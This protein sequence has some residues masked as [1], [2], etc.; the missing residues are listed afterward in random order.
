MLSGPPLP[1]ERSMSDET[2]FHLA[3]EQ[4]AAERAGFLDGA[5][6]G[7][8]ALR[9]RVEVLLHAHEN[10]AGFLQSPAI[11]SGATLED[12]SAGRPAP[13]RPPGTP[14]PGEIIGPYKLLQEIGE[15]GMGIVWMAEQMQPVQRKVALKIIKPGLDSRMIIARFE[16]ERQALALMDHVNIARVLDA[17]ATAAGKPYFVMELVHGVPITQYCDDHRLNPRQRLELFVPVCQA[18]QH[19]HQKGIIHRDIKPSNVMVTLYDGKPVPKVIDFGVAK[20]T[21]QK[22]TERTLFTQY[23]TMVGTLEYMS[24]EQAEMSALGVDTRSDIFSLGVLL[25]E[26]LTGSTPL[27]H[28]RMKDAA[29]AEILRMIKEE[30]PPKP[31]TR[32]TDSGEALASISANRHTEPAKLTK[33]V[34]GE[35]DWIVMK[36]LEKDRNR[37]YE[38]ASAFATDVQHHLAD[39]PVQACPPSAWYRFGKFARRNRVALTTAATISAALVLAVA[40]LV[41]TVSV[42][43]A[44]NAG[45]KEKQQQTEKA[46]D[47]EKN[48]KDELLDVLK[49]EQRTLY[50]KRIALAER[51][52]A[53]NNLGRLEEFLDECPLNL[54]GWE[55]RYLRRGRG[56]V[57]F[58]G[59]DSWV[60][61][62][63]FSPDGKQIASASKTGEIKVWERAT[64]NEVHR[65]LG[66]MAPAFAVAYRPDGKQLASAGWDN[67]VRIWDLQTGKQLSSLTEH[68]EFVSAVVYSPDGKFLASASGDN[69]IL[70][71]DAVTLQK[72]HTLHGDKHTHLAFAPDSRRLAASGCVWDAT[73]GQKL[74]AIA[75][76]KGRFRRVLFSP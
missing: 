15:G 29:F 47:G 8:S 17:G 70:I 25:Y 60:Y 18:I 61:G 3:L 33:L 22:L 69:L 58:Q 57:T 68:R 34:R 62:V 56:P 42:L 55:W 20:A 41:G 52:L 44:S 51:E 13:A 11:S 43:A 38:S 31:S 64:G 76:D 10:P 2:L 7:D 53:A 40:S 23:G 9:R 27:T 37:R 45:I 36:A 4:A 73:S 49:R 28:Q 59:H 65:L 66:H 67:T 19:A 6:A 26:L 30:E 16:A 50:L 63:A 48:A 74:Y 75:G 46:L 21:E 72:L 24:P 32:L 39:E 12:S 35:L 14:A 5:C 1:R 54:R 71:W